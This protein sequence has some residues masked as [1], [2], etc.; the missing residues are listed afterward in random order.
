MI[1][2]G[3]FVWTTLKY[4]IN[5]MGKKN[6]KFKKNNQKKIFFLKIGMRFLCFEQV[7]IDHLIF[8]FL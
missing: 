5:F 3:T 6:P 2:K 8:L 4:K 7:K 1:M